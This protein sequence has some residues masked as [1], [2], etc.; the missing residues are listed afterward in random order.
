MYYLKRKVKE[1]CAV[2]SG[3]E[4]PSVDNFHMHFMAPAFT[5]TDTDGVK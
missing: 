3:P 5:L 1:E 2:F 4:R